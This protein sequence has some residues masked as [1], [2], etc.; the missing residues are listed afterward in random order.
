MEK[1]IF[2][3]G[4]FVVFAFL[5]EAGTIP[6]KKNGLGTSSEEES[7][8]DNSLE[9]KENEENENSLQELKD[10]VGPVILTKKETKFLIPMWE[11]NVHGMVVVPYTFDPIA[12]FGM[13]RVSCG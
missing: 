7:L 3:L 13:S 12:G 8:E 6:P 4:C 9:S 5:A 2:F 1:L 10:D 11:K